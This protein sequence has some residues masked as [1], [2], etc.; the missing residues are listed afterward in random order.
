MY[1]QEVKIKKTSIK[2]VC[3][4]GVP[5]LVKGD[6]KL[7][8]QNFAD[9]SLVFCGFRGNKVAKDVWGGLYLFDTKGSKTPDKSI[10]VAE[11]K[12]ALHG[13]PSLTLG[14]TVLPSSHPR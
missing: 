2:D 13:G 1:K 8:G 7:N 14:P 12:K 5:L 11:L 9:G 6:Y 3:T 10:T 4:G